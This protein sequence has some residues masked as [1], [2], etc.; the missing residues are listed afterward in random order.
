M[1]VL[2]KRYKN[3]NPESRASVSG[4]ESR[5][6]LRLTPPPSAKDRR[7]KVYNYIEAV[8][9]LPTCFTSLELGTIIP[10]VEA[11][12]SG[13]L[14]SVFICLSD[15]LIRPSF[16]GSAQSSASGSSA[17]RVATDTGHDEADGED[18]KNIRR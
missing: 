7:V 6:M 1:K 11:G 17:K 2:A 13:S 10:K 8:T 15:D 18:P 3:S 4:Y 12:F 14:R 5:P 9:K 16:R